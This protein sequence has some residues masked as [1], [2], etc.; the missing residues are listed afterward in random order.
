MEGMA[1]ELSHFAEKSGDT[2]LA[3]LF[4]LAAQEA[5]ALQGHYRF[6]AA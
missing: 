3:Y 2:F 1:M 5:H 6:E 4:C